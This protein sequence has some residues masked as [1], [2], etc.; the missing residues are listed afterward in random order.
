MTSQT[1]SLSSYCQSLPPVDLRFLVTEQTNFT[2]FI[3]LQTSTVS[4][5]HLPPSHASSVLL[6]YWDYLH[7]K[8]FLLSIDL[9]LPTCCFSALL[10]Y[11][12]HNSQKTFL[13]HIE[14]TFGKS[15]INSDGCSAS[16][17]KKT[18]IVRHSSDYRSVLGW[19]TKSLLMMLNSETCLA[20]I[21]LAE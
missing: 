21:L 10:D 7:P 17:G 1:N 15:G 12:F 18:L 13:T 2:I 8:I 6:L 14:C 11:T 16:Y 20:T 5:F 3:T 19:I 4:S 9:P